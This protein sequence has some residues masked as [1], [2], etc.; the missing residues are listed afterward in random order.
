[1]AT[2]EYT[3][4]NAMKCMCVRCPVQASS[5]CVAEK[6]A[7]LSAAMEVGMDAMPATADVPLLYCATGIAVCD[8]L[9]FAQRC[10]CG[11]CAVF[12]ENALTQMKYC[13]RGSA[14]KIG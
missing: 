7:L 2:V 5:S 8:D 14:A 10:I 12:S 13:K 1:M 6:S 11:D 9:D 3:R 4:A